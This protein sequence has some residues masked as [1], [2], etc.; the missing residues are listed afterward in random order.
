[1]VRSCSPETVNS[2]NQ[3]KSVQVHDKWLKFNVTTGN[4]KNKGDGSYLKVLCLLFYFQKYSFAGHVEPDV[5]VPKIF[6]GQVTL[7]RLSDCHGHLSPIFR[8]FSV[9]IFSKS[10]NFDEL[11]EIS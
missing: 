7:S 6:V 9:D 11:F 10:A 8:T 3:I 4:C 1:M 2:T 5:P